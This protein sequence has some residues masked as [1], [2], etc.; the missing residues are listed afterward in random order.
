MRLSFTVL[1]LHHS[2]TDQELRDLA[3]FL[4]LIKPKASYIEKL[5]INFFLEARVQLELELESLS[6]N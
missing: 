2:I 6:C 3:S 1:L 5:H 4:L